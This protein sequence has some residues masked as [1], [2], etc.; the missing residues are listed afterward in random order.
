MLGRM[1]GKENQ[2]T[3]SLREDCL[4]LF[5]IVEEETSLFTHVEPRTLSVVPILLRIVHFKGHWIR[6]PESWETPKQ[7]EKPT[8][9]IRSLAAHLF[10]RYDIPSGFDSVWEINGPLDIPQR[11]WYCHLAAGG[12]L[13]SAPDMAARLTKRAAHW[14]MQAPTKYTV[15]E[16]LRYGQVMA[17]AGYIELVDEVLASP[18]GTDFEADHLWIPL[19]ES[20]CT[21]NRPFSELHLLAD[22]IDSKK[23]SGGLFRF[24]TKRRPWNELI[25]EATRAFSD[26]KKAA[27]N[28]GAIEPGDCDIKSPA[29]RRRLISFKR[30]LWQPQEDIQPFHYE[31]GN[32]KCGWV[33]EIKELCSQQALVEEGQ[34]MR[35]CI[36]SYGDLCMQG[37]SAIFSL[38]SRRKKDLNM[39]RD[40]TIEVRLDRREI[41]QATS[42]CNRRPHPLSAKVIRVWAERNHIH[43]S[44]WLF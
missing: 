12:C 1:F 27:V 19:I 18:I 26:L 37:I 15:T 10:K 23:G 11:R 2:W 39:E 9:I 29:S 30:T 5:A 42:W 33:W 8:A 13:R 36:A 16:A 6:S 41:W 40:V 38:T 7:T 44:K 25:A 3:E 43:I 31:T 32:T 22:Y 20:M 24:Q 28:S 4:Q 35:H 34:D 17:T 21:L 14:A